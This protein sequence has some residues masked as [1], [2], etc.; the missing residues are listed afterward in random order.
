MNARTA[1]EE[2][3]VVKDVAAIMDAADEM[4]EAANKVKAARRVP[5]YLKVWPSTFVGPPRPVVVN[6]PTVQLYRDALSR[7]DWFYHRS[8]DPTAYRA[9]RDSFEHILHLQTLLDPKR[10]IWREYAAKE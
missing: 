3:T 7:H 8:D 5:D 2:R 9:G 1:W 6:T 4:L 10:V